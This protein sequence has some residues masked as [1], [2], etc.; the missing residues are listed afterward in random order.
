[1]RQCAQSSVKD[2]RLVRLLLPF[3]LKSREKIGRSDVSQFAD[4]CR[5][6]RNPIG[7]MVTKADYCRENPKIARKTFNVRTKLQFG[8]WN[9][10]LDLFNLLY[11]PSD[12]ILKQ[13]SAGYLITNGFRSL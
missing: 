7:L 12:I 11:E 10:F 2:S 3:V 6:T 1:M 4:R 5:T 9:N 13:K 8:K